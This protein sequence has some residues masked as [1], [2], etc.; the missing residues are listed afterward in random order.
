MTIPTTVLEYPIFAIGDVHGQTVFLQRLL[1]QL[2]CLPE[3][4]AARIVFLGDLV[5]RGPDVRC[6][7]QTVWELLA[8]KPGS[9]CVMGNHDFALVRAAGLDDQPPSPSWAKRYRDNYDHAATFQSYLGREPRRHPFE[10]WCEDLAALREA[11]P[12]DH[13]HFLAHLPWLAESAGHLFLHNGLSP[14]L[15]EPASVQWELLR[16]QK[17]HGYVH[18]R[19]GTETAFHYNPEYPVWLGADK[20]LSAHPLPVPGRVIVSGHVRVPTPDGNATRIRIDT[21]GGM[22]E[23]LTACLLRGPGEPPAFFFSNGESVSPI[24]TKIGTK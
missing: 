2:R 19:L 24:G 20:R 12:E 18:P 8:E 3:W 9:V 4:K 14:E 1:T 13:R 23:P 10:D 11:M 21:S 6:A 15:E 5:D 17:W 7:V 22:Q 16:Q